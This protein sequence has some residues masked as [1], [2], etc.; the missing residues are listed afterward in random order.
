MRLRLLAA[1]SVT[2]ASCTATLPSAPERA[3]A[4]PPSAIPPELQVCW[5]EFSRAQGPAWPTTKGPTTTK[6]FNGTVSSLVVRHPQGDVAVDIG[7]STAMK[8]DWADYPFVLRK[9]MDLAPGRMQW[10]VPSHAAAFEKVGVSTTNSNLRI[11]LSHAHADH[12]GGV[13][14]VPGV[15]ILTTQAE[16]DFVASFAGKPSL[17]VVPAHAKRMEGRLTA[18]EFGSGP[19]ETFDTS[20]DL[21]GDGSVVLVPMPGHTPGSVGTFVNLP[22]GRRL[23]HIGDVV[24]LAEG[25]EKSVP[26]GKLVKELD[27]DHAA[28]N[29]Q[30]AAVH[31]LAKKAPKLTVLPAHDRN[32]WEAFF[33]K[34]SGVCAP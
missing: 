13:G 22:D 20:H 12:A 6:K 25:I 16:I 10:I 27:H 23:F 9:K 7:N 18:V 2:L 24:M 8:K 31:A 26:K 3:R 33:G 15:P 17:H 29:A 5:A 19:Y 1:L 34:D 21:F 11:I 32:V 14:D 30:V 28:T 4:E